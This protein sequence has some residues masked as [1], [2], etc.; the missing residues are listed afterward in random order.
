MMIAWPKIQE[1]KCWVK[2]SGGSG[3]EV[4]WLFASKDSTSRLNRNNDEDVMDSVISRPNEG[5][6]S[7]F[8]S[9]SLWSEVVR[10]DPG[11]GPKSTVELE[12]RDDRDSTS[13]LLIS[14][15]MGTPDG[16]AAGEDEPDT[17]SGLEVSGFWSGTCHT[18]MWLSWSWSEP[19]STKVYSLGQKIPQ[20]K[21]HAKTF[22]VEFAAVC[23]QFQLFVYISKLQ[24][25]DY[26]FNF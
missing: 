20:I 1:L 17:G 26:Y 4:S 14:G 8:C 11:A 10:P 13:S 24:L 22:L 16:A 25:F 5:C 2:S 23:L 15:W 12:P 6:L 21:N 7:N 3:S 9:A 19:S 18:M